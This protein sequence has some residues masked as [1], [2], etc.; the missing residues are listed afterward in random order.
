[1]RRFGSVTGK[2][3]EK[4]GDE[5]SVRVRTGREGDGTKTR[6]GTSAET[7]RDAPEDVE[8]RAPRATGAV[9]R[10]RSVAPRR[11][12]RTP[13]RGCG[14]PRRP[15]AERRRRARG[16]N[17]RGDGLARVVDPEAASARA[18][19]SSLQTD[20]FGAF[21]VRKPGT[22]FRQFAKTVC[23]GSNYCTFFVSFFVVSRY[24]CSSTRFPTGD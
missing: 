16:S 22:S 7:H 14:T 20:A 18:S 15:S 9:A 23:L 6:E 5:G 3:E 12:P 21:R 13:S 1:M 10:A 4:G 8:A 19:I 17:G 2:E 24:G 11:I